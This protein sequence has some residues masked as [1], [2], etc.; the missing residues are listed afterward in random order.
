VLAGHVKKQ[1]L[2]VDQFRVIRV[3]LPGCDLNSIAGLT[4]EIFFNVVDD[5]H[6]FAGPSQDRQVLDIVLRG[7]RLLVP[8]LDSVLAVETV[9]YRAGLV[10]RIQD[11][12]GI[13]LL[14]GCEDD[15]LELIRHRVKELLSEGPN[16]EHHLESQVLQLLFGRVASMLGVEFLGQLVKVLLLLLSRL[17]HLLLLDVRVDQRL[18]EV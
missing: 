7:A 4:A 1:A 6:G 12:V 16:V 2:Q 10:E 15:E 8:H 11:L 14:T 9:R 3:I 13:I 17:E 5:D 18:V